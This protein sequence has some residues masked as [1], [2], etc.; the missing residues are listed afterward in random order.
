MYECLAYEKKYGCQIVWKSWNR[1]LKPKTEAAL[2]G[3]DMLVQ[4]PQSCW[5][6][7]ESSHLWRSHIDTW[8]H[9]KC[10]SSTASYLPQRSESGLRPCP[11]VVKKCSPP[12]WDNAPMFRHKAEPSLKSIKLFWGWLGSSQL[13]RHFLLKQEQYG[14]EGKKIKYRSNWRIGYV[15]RKTVPEN[16]SF[17]Y[18]EA[19]LNNYHDETI[20]IDGSITSVDVRSICTEHVS[21]SMLEQLFHVRPTLTSTN[22]GDL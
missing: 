15:K 13:C 19:I 11:S 14:R 6:R 3:I 17:K 2:Q 20:C 1:L 9:Q 22:L 4:N 18:K 16:G 5:Q 10:W 12:S 8:S 21:W 7:W